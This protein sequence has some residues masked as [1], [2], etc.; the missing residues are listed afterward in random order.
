MNDLKIFENAEFGQIRTVQLN[1]DFLGYFYLLEYGGHVKIGSTKQPHIRM[2]ALRRNA[3][4][5]GDVR[6]GRLALSTPHTN[7]RENEKTL[8]Q[9]FKPYR[10]SGTELFEVAF[11]DALKMFAAISIKYLDESDE[12]DR[13]ADIVCDGFKRFLLGGV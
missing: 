6:I 5:Y 2:Q 9:S 10:K 13:N 4:S 8:H 12:L 3:E 11:D 7:Y 1:N